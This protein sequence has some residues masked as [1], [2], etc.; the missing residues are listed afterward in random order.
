MR[1]FRRFILCLVVSVTAFGAAGWGFRPR[2]S[3]E[4]ETP[5]LYRHIVGS[6]HQLSDDDPVWIES[7]QDRAAAVR[8][9]FGFGVQFNFTAAANLRRRSPIL[10]PSE[11]MSRF[12]VVEPSAVS[13]AI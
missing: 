1:L 9:S 6:G 11:S 8:C 4:V 5:G 3:W 13:Q 10:L 7:N 12:R 2:A